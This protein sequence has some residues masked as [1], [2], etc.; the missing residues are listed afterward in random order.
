MPEQQVISANFAVLDSKR[1]PKEPSINVPAD[2]NIGSVDAALTLNHKIDGTVPQIH[3]DETPP[4]APLSFFQGKFAG[5]GFNTI[6]RPSNP[7][8]RAKAAE[9]P[10]LVTKFPK[11]INTQAM[12]DARVPDDNILELNLTR[13]SWC[14]STPLGQVPNRG[15]Q[16]QKDIILLGVP[17]TQSVRNVTNPEN[18]TGDAS[19]GGPI[20]FE[21]GLF[22][23]APKLENPESD[24]P[25][26]SRLA[27]IPHGTTIN[28]SGPAPDAHIE[29][30]GPPIFP[31]ID[32]IPRV[33]P[34]RDQISAFPSL[35]FDTLDAARLPQDLTL[36]RRTG[37]IT[38]ESFK[39]PNLVLK[40]FNAPLG[41][42]IVSHYEF[43]VATSSAT[44]TADVADASGI[45][46][47]ANAHLPGLASISFLDKP[48]ANPGPNADVVKMKA[49]F[50]VSKVSYNIKVDPIKK[51]ETREIA[52]LDALP[53]AT[54]P[55]FKIVADRDIAKGGTITVFARH[56]QYSQNVLLVFGGL[57]WPHVSLAS[58][59]PQ[60]VVLVPTADLSRLV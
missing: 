49:T 52:P 22:L 29:T 54:G 12:K 42:R 7:E 1:F 2:F 33:S 20:H 55:K 46:P 56:I 60:D 59:I 24:G 21:P 25:T 45:V 36:F 3:D 9:D 58:L 31:K 11:D 39:N 16:G 41:N 44:S 34:A 37:A 8:N 51:G 18:G 13:E 47:A 50:W 32:I 28:A 15:S 10:A 43:T 6:F 26:I 23:H 17:Y 35:T 4:P 5:P 19:P 53:S 14:F 30:P 27:S 57:D 40:S 48:R 38:E